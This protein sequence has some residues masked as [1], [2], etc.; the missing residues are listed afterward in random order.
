[1]NKH[2]LTAG[3]VIVTAAAIA[4]C[5]GSGASTSGGNGAKDAPNAKVEKPAKLDKQTLKAVHSKIAASVPSKVPNAVADRKYVTM[6][7][8]SAATGGGTAGGEIKSGLSKSSDYRITVFFIDKQA[9]V[10]GYGHT[11][12]SAKPGV[13]TAWHLTAKFTTAPGTSCVLRGVAAS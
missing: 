12:V 13:K 11:S 10:I 1:M 8:C 3:A 6:S 4:G 9:T 7:S 2:V 5:G